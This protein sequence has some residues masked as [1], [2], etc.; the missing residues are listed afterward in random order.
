MVSLLDF[1]SVPEWYQTDEK[2][3]FHVTWRRDPVLNESIIAKP[4]VNVSICVNPGFG[5]VIGYTEVMP[6]AG[7]T[8]LSMR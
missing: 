4:P 6:R 7:K 8:R 2:R 5:R 3:T 1:V